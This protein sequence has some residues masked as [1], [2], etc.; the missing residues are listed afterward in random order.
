[1]DNIFVDKSIIVTPC[2]ISTSHVGKSFPFVPHFLPIPPCPFPFS[3]HSWTPCALELSLPAALLLGSTSSQLSAKMY[4]CTSEP[5]DVISLLWWGSS[6]V[7]LS[8]LTGTACA[9]HCQLAVI[10][11]AFPCARFLTWLPWRWRVGFLA[12]A[13]FCNFSPSEVVLMKYKIFPRNK[14]SKKF[15]LHEVPT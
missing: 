10:H 2:Q 12:V 4:I 15:K 9:I 8:A 1:L 5:F 3:A 14:T 13:F 7:V 6:P 11:S